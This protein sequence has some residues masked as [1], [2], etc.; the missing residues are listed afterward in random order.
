[1]DKERW[2]DPTTF[3]PERFLDEKGQLT[4]NECFIPFGQGTDTLQIIYCTLLLLTLMC[5]L[6]SLLLIL[7]CNTNVYISL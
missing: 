3:R 1:M 7:V 5:I 4:Q 6:V 2:M